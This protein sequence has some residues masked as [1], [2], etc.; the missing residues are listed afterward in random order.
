MKRGEEHAPWTDHHPVAEHDGRAVEE[1][2]VEI[3]EAVAADSD[4]V[5][6][7]ETQAG[8]DEGV[9]PDMSK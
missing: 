9:F 3:K 4:V 7:V 2:A 6:V 1:R 5:A 8:H